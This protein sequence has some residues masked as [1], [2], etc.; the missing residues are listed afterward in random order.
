MLTFV[1]AK[2]I[3]DQLSSIL[4]YAIK[5]INLIKV[6]ALNSQVFKSLCEEIGRQLKILF[7]HTEMRWLSRILNILFELRSEVILFLIEKHD[8]QS[9]L[10]R[11]P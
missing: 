9:A 7:F 10:D 6:R 2:N 8:W 11:F 3:P 5:V 4:K 1:L